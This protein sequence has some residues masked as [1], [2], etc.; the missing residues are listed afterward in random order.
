MKT[1]LSQISSLNCKH[2]GRWM[3]SIIVYHFT[4]NFFFRFI[5]VVST[6]DIFS[7]RLSDV[8]VFSVQSLF[9]YAL[10]LLWVHVIKCICFI[11]Q[12]KIISYR[13][14]KCIKSFIYKHYSS[15]TLTLTVWLILYFIYN[16]V[17][18]DWK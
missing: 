5:F 12:T 16:C 18:Y 15:T 6:T 10:S 17:L 11:F 2:L 1:T 4:I 3:T 9:V 8:T 14:G 7:M 13:V